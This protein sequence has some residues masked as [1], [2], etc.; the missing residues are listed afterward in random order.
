MPQVRRALRISVRIRAAEQVPSVGLE[1]RHDVLE[2]VALG[3]H[4]AG[5]DVEGVARDGVPVV[6]DCV[7]QRVSADLGCAAG[8][9]VDVVPLHGDQVAGT[10][11]VDSPVVVAVAGGAP[12]G[13]AVKLAVGEGHAV[14]C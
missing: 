3:Y 9:V 5:G 12:A 14:R 2:D 11:Q 7:Q 1:R 4:V 8:G 6:V 13:V 10:R